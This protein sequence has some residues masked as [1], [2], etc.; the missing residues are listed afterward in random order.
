MKFSYSAVVAP[1]PD[2]GE[3]LVIFRP[4]V[5]L[6][7]HGPNGSRQYIAL[8]DT[9]A[10]NTILPIAVAHHFGIETVAAQGPAAVAF[11]GQR[12][13]LSYADVELSL[14]DSDATLRWLARVFFVEDAESDEETLVVGHQ[15]FLD[16]F[17]AIFDG[18]ECE[19]ELIPTVELPSAS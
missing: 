14:S 16:F 7:L 3:Q 10:D 1:A 19:L 2:S 9:G 8:V 17:V 13:L 4:E 11:G 18:S 6:T 5:P 12:I 15:G